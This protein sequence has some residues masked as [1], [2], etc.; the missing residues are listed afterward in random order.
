MPERTAVIETPL[1]RA[2]IATTGGQVKAWDLHFRG[3]KPMVLPGTVD[4]AG[5]VVK[6]PGQPARPIAFALSTE[7]IK[8]DKDTP[9]G[10]LRMVGEDGFGIRVSQVLRFHADSYVVEHELKVENRHTVAQA[11][12]L[13]QVWSAP[14]EWPKA[15]EQF[16]RGAA[17]PRRAPPA[18][19]ALVSP[20]VPQPRRWTTRARTGGS[21]SRAGSPRL[22]R[23]AST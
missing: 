2:A 1:Y 18:R 11:V 4:T 8:L 7:S 17:D 6:R 3:E 20:R 14:A 15:Q 21:A 19:L 22:A 16:A 12:E 10:E 13:A 9:T 23:T 5:W